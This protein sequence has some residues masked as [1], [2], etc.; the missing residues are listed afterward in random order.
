[1]AKAKRTAGV[2]ASAK[3]KLKSLDLGKYLDEVKFG[4]FKLDDIF[5][6]TSKNLQ[7][8]ADANRKIIDGY[9]DIARRQFDMLKGLL[10]DLRK[11]GGGGSDTVKELKKVVEQAR[12][13]VQVLQKMA[14]KTNAAAQKIVKKRSDANL[15]AWKKLVAD[16]KKSLGQKSDAV[17]KPAAKKKATAKKKAA[18]K[19]KAAV[20]KKSAAKKRAAPRRK[21]A[22]TSAAPPASAG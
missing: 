1:M 3:K 6:G 10:E 2:K 18:P 11:V 13:D 9:I 21:A 7:A 20:K 16:A 19:K 15:K 5:D 4:S 12:K 22:A 8:V 14:S 17:K